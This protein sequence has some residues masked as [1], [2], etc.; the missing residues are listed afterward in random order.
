MS[1]FKA[2]VSYFMP[3][4]FASVLLSLF[5]AISFM[6]FL[7]GG[8]WYDSR[9]LSRFL[10]FFGTHHFFR[11]IIPYFILHFL[12]SHVQWRSCVRCW[13]RPTPT[14][15]ERSL[16]SF[17]ELG[18]SPALPAFAYPYSLNLCLLLFD[19][20]GVVNQDDFIRIMGERS[21]NAD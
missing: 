7:L 18:F 19:R 11:V 20:D 4:L 15:T 6:D 13:T 17:P 10:T 21:R 3:L 8:Y 14:G 12:D 1:S 16:V 2:F 9:S 5:L